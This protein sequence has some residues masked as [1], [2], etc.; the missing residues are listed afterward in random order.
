MTE[1]AKYSV[2]IL[3]VLMLVGGIMGY[4]KAQS[5]ASL[6]SGVGSAVILAICFAVTLSNASYGF[7]GAAATT[8]I[9]EFVF[10][11][12]LAK[13]KKFM[14]SGM[15]LIVNGIVMAIVMFALIVPSAGSPAG[16]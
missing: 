3:S 5:K 8:A 11:V 13:T 10:A 9:L 14:P 6:I 2:L 12:R 1:I 7:V 16:S 4:V 15:L